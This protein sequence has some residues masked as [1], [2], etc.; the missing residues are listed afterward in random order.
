MRPIGSSGFLTVL[1]LLSGWAAVFAE[2]GRWHTQPDLWTEPRIYHTSFDEEFS[3]RVMVVKDTLFD[4]A[5]E[6]V[7]SPNR[8]YWFSK[9][10]PQF[11][12]EGPW[13]TSVC[14]FQ[15]REYLLRI[16]LFDHDTVEPEVR[17]I[18]EKLLYVQVWWGKILGTT[19]IFDVE[20]ENFIDKEMVHWGLIDFQQWHPDVKDSP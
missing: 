5:A 16:S 10:V 17:W 2:G 9:E 11:S 8:A 19:M 4:P 12:E 13:N 20:E 3:S 7:F 14:V 18:N 6:R 15:E 1:A